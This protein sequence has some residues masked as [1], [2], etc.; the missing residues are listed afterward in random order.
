MTDQKAAYA[1]GSTAATLADGVKVKEPGQLTQRVLHELLDD[2]IV[3][4]EAEGWRIEWHPR[5]EFEG[6]DPALALPAAAPISSTDAAAS[7]DRVATSSSRA[8]RES[9]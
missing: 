5:A 9:R 2:I 1:Q 6:E 3:V 8:M 7:L 4:R